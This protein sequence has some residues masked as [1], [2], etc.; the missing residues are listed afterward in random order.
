MCRKT[1]LLAFGLLVG[2]LSY[3]KAQ[4]PQGDRITGVWVTAEEDGRVKI[5]K[6]DDGSFYG[7]LIWTKNQE[8]GKPL[9][10]DVNN[11][12]PEKQDRT[13]LG[14][15]LLKDLTYNAEDDQ[16]VDGKIYDPKKGKS[17]SCYVELVNPDKLKLRG[18]VG[19]SFV[20]RTTHWHRYKP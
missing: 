14:I 18:Y 2:G 8:T 13:L 5:Q 4:E 19:V 16:W 1:L 6:S 17:Y 20:G 12:D 9:K 3:P 15:R 7:K 11:P 10:K